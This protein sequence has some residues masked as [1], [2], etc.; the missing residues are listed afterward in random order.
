MPDYDLGL[1]DYR[2]EASSATGS[3]D[4][5]AVLAFW[6]REGAVDAEE[7]KIRINEVLLVAI[8]GADEV[9]A[10]STV[11][12][13]RNPQLLMSFWHTRAYVGKAHRIANGLRAGTVWINCYDVFDVAAPF[14]GYKMS[15]VGRELGMSALDLYT[16]TKNVFIDLS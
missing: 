2:I 11:Y 12:L 16:E 4:E 6:E 14:G 8:D 15:G 1:E 7:A 9:A 13:Q 10:V 3:F 5:A